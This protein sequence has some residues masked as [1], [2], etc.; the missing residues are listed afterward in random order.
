[1]NLS[2]G[3]WITI[4]GIILASVFALITILLKRGKSQNSNINI[5]QNQGAFSKGSQNVN[6]NSSQT[7]EKE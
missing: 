3:N 6:L 2:T 1:M 5:N 7:D 4:I